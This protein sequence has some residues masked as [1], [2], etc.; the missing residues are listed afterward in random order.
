MTAAGLTP[1]QQTL[2][3]SQS[4]L[5]NLQ[6]ELHVDHQRRAYHALRALLHALR[7]RESNS[8]GNGLSTISWGTDRKQRCRGRDDFG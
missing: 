5:E 3:F 1:F 7:D 8:A 2:E 6:Q 4:W